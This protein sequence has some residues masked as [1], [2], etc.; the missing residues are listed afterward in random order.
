[1][2]MYATNHH[3]AFVSKHCLISEQRKP[4]YFGREQ[5]QLAARADSFYF[6]QADPDEHN[7]DEHIHIST[8]SLI[9]SVLL[10][11]R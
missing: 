8:L 4:K 3:Q 2:Q 10:N 1:M 11:Q 6:A 7:A 9:S 5:I